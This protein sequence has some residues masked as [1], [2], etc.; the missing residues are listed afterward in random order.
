MGI[1]QRFARMT[2]QNR[3]AALAGPLVLAL[4]FGFVY[5]VCGP[6]FRRVVD[7]IANGHLFDR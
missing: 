7:F 5:T 4:F 1:A 6:E 2:E 3:T